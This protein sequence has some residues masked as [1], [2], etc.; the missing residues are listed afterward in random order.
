MARIL[1]VEDEKDI[2]DVIAFNLKQAGH[3]VPGGRDRGRG[4][5]RPW[6][7]RSPRWCSST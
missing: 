5:S 1:I 6:P 4:A 3:E 2:R 7:R